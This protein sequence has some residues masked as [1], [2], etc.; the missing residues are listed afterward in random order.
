MDSYLSGC[1]TNKCI[2]IICFLPR[3]GLRHIAGALAP[4][5]NYIYEEVLNGL[6]GRSHKLNA[7]PPSGL[8][9]FDNA[10]EAEATSYTRYP[11]RGKQIA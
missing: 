11:L 3:K 7:S 8:Q 4:C 6:K 9:I 5:S 1:V 2:I 10:L